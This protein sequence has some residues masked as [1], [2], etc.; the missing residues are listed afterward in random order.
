M[1]SSAMRCRIAGV[2]G[3]PPVATRTARAS[4]AAVGCH[5]SM[6]ST[7]GAPL[8]CVTFDSR[9]C[10]HTTP[11]IELAQAQMR[12]AR[13]SHA[14]REAPAVAVEHRQR[15]EEGAVAVEPR[16]QRHRQR[17]QVGAAVVVH[18]ALRLAGGAARVVDRDQPA[19]VGHRPLVRSGRW[20][21]GART[22][23]R[24]ARRAPAA[25]RRPTRAAMSRATLSN[26]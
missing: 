25:S 3:A 8:K 9:R 13:S 19:L 15:P 18:D 4:L 6:T 7:V 26:S 10:F 21:A 20:R 2:G 14:P 17:L 1:P 16:F 5:A 12:R 24:A 22:G 11:G 23:R